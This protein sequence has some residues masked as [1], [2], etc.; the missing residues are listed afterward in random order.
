MQ[1]DD[2]QPDLRPLYRD[3]RLGG[4]LG[5][6]RADFARVG[7]ARVRIA[8]AV[9]AYRAHVRVHQ[10]IASAL[11]AAA[12]V[13]MGGLT[14]GG[15]GGCQS[16]RGDADVISETR[17]GEFGA[18]RL[19][20]ANRATQD[21]SNRSYML[22]RMKIMLLAQAD[23]VPESAE[24]I[25]DRLYDFLRTQ[26][27]NRDNTV[28]SFFVGEQG[29]R[30]WKGE[31]FE[32]AMAYHAISVFDATRGD[33]GNVRACAGNSLFALRDFS[34][35]FGASGYRPAAQAVNPTANGPQY[36]AQT[37]E[38]LALL[39]NAARVEQA[40]GGDALSRYTPSRSD[41]EV[42]YAMHAIAS[43]Q[44]G[45]RQDMEES[46]A[47]LA[48]MRPEMAA[49][50]Q[51]IATGRYNTVLVV[52]YG[53]APRKIGAGPDNTIAIFQPLTASD[54]AALQVSVN[55]R[56]AGTF[57]VVTDVNRLA[58]DLK[59]NNLEDMRRAKSTLGDVLLVGGAAVAVG[60]EDDEAKMAGAAAAIAGL[61]LKA[62]AAA[63][64]RYCEVLPQRVYIAPVWL[65]PGLN[66]VRLE[67][68][69][70][71]AMVIPD[72]PAPPDSRVFARYVRLSE[73]MG[74][75]SSSDQVLYSNDVSGAARVM[76]QIAPAT[77]RYDEA[78]NAV[79]VAATTLPARAA[80]LP[81]ILGGACVRLPT[82]EVL[83]A[84][85]RAGFLRG[86][87]LNDLIDLYK[88]EGIWL[89]NYSQVPGPRRHILEGGNSLYTPEPGS[90]GFVRLYAQPH[91]RY[92]ARSARVQAL[93]EECRALLGSG[94]SIEAETR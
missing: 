55:G 48:N 15:L 46:V 49:L 82:D 47:A 28:A 57:P 36:D 91:A 32:Q 63:D 31:P 83:S 37:N 1:W 18:A 61:L 24:S 87:S 90:A 52:D 21:P 62:T 70:R 51:V 88:E 59:W 74:G 50:A 40:G 26:G 13:A 29:A 16:Y 45:E 54:N 53:L 66:T 17:A 77:V 27:V 72:V 39:E 23:G 19:V 78:G 85:Q 3:V 6:A 4:G 33:W 68:P 35:T 8:R 14:I 92:V 34:K 42:G 44:L 65:E 79:R 81:Y 11:S 76:P 38:K 22:D 94:P 30:V 80:D 60:A 73:R 5:R 2:F 75:W 86:M 12:V 10:R 71:A 69:G 93:A 43:R 84:Y 58:Q 64:T 56:G 7:F 20:A 41:F 9:H 67:I 89:E 25:A